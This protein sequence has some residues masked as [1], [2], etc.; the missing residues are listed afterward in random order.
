MQMPG[1]NIDRG[2]QPMSQHS[3]S[4]DFDEITTSDD[5]VTSLGWEDWDD[6]DSKPVYRPV[7]IERA[8]VP[9]TGVHPTVIKIGLSVAA[10][11]AAVAWLNFAGGVEVDFTLAVVTGF[12]VMF[13]TLFL[14]AGWT[15]VDDPRWKQPKANFTNFSRTM[16]PSTGASITN[17]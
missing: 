13:F 16:F 5:R 12:F 3:L 14:L 6:P 4:Q 10:W 17:T 8:S 9:T 1:L 7:Q 15:I 2:E 11:F